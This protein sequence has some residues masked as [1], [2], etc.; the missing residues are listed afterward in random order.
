MHTKPVELREDG[1]NTIR[2]FLFFLNVLTCL[3]AELFTLWTCDAR[4]DGKPQ[5]SLNVT[6]AGTAG[7]V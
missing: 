4:T 7:L 2:L 6:G 3:A 5:S 1:C